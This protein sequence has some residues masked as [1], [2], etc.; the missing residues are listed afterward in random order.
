MFN[1]LALD[2]YHA[3]FQCLLQSI[4]FV[5]SVPLDL[6]LRLLHSPITSSLTQEGQRHHKLKTGFNVLIGYTVTGSNLISWLFSAD[7]SNI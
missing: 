2:L 6:V 5:I 3:A 1:I 4:I 7:S